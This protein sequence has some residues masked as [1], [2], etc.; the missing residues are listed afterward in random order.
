MYFESVVVV[1]NR[2]KSCCNTNALTIEAKNKHTIP[3]TRDH[4]IVELQTFL[5]HIHPLF[6]CW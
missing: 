4:Q 5:T 6:K 2:R 1:G 3:I